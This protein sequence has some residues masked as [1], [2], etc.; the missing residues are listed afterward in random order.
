MDSPDKRDQ[1]EGLIK[2]TLSA[3]DIIRG[4]HEK[5]LL[6]IDEQYNKGSF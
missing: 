1:M 5:A 3:D 6:Y 2:K 4:A